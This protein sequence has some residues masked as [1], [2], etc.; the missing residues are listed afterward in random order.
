MSNENNSHDGIQELNGGATIRVTYGS[1]R[2]EVM[3]AG[4]AEAT[5][6][7]QGGVIRHTVGQEAEAA[8]TITKHQ[9]YTPTGTPGASIMSTAKRDRGGISVELT[10]G[11]ASSRTV[12]QTA[13]RDGLVREVAPG[14]FVDVAPV[15][16][17][18]QGQQPQQQEEVQQQQGDSLFDPQDAADWAADIADVPQA[19]YDNAAARITQAVVTGTFDVSS[20]AAKLAQEGGMS[21][22][23]A[24][25]YVTQGKALYQRTVDAALGRQGL[26]GAEL[27]QCYAYMRQ[28]KPSALAHALQAL[29]HQADLGPLK[30]LAGLY[31]EETMRKG[32]AR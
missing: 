8:G 26:E 30:K 22:E 2:Q 15:G 11:D 9:T 14:Q 28:Q 23:L 17:P 4:P 5:R 31:Q 12:I 7:R 20:I 32:R 6:A 24:A 3:Q 19:A 13:V 29:H 21:L 25:D 1:V 18:A 16:Q 10:P 27:Q